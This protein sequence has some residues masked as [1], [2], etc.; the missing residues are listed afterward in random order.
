MPFT[1]FRIDPPV[2][3]HR[4]ASQYAPE[5]T[6]TAFAKAKA[7]GI[8]WLEFD[9]MLSA[10]DQLVVIHDDT[11]DRTTDGS[12]YVSDHSYEQ[13]SALDA[14]FWFEPIFAGEKIPLL[15][16]L[17]QWMDKE[18][19]LANIEI[20]AMPG[21]EQLTAMRVLETIKQNWSKDIAQLLISSF[22]LEVLHCVRK[23]DTAC[24]MGL[25]M[26]EWMPEWEKVCDELQCLS[27]NPNEKIVDQAKIAQFKSTGR[28]VF[29]YTVNDVHRARELFSW[30]VDAVYSDCPD[31]I[32]AAL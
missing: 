6:M 21:K 11:I 19:M 27:V 18:Q 29:C 26:H 13:L 15:S 17:L 24:S 12:G 2:F 25:L 22:S 28:S 9:V 23:L 16:D 7:L 3:A 5:N 32:V 10:D 31:K 1:K 14:G 4:G 8:R 30:G 20:K